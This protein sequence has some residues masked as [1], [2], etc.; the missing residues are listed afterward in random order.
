MK[1]GYTLQQA[2]SILN[3]SVAD[4]LQMLKRH[5]L[6][7]VYENGEWRLSM[8][9][10]DNKSLH[11]EGN[12]W[13]VPTTRTS[14]PRIERKAQPTS[15]KPVFGIPKAVREATPLPASSVAQAARYVGVSADTIHQLILQGQVRAR[16]D[17]NGQWLVED[18]DVARLA[19]ERARRIA[20]TVK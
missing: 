15:P 16:R 18:R 20:H 3:T 6:G 19:Q 10:V 1:F 11:G 4:I 8:V 13:A 9:S 17:M 12:K 2:A 14:N 7:G 5:E